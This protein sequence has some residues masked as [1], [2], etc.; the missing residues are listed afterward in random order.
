M[1]SKGYAI[2]HKIKMI[3]PNINSQKDKKVA[4]IF[5][6]NIFYTDVDCN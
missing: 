6:Y 2:V 1:R 4:I 3:N 5:R